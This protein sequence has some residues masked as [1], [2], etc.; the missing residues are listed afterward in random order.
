MYI[1]G[2]DSVLVL[3]QSCFI[4]TNSAVVSAIK[5][6]RNGEN[7]G[8]LLVSFVARLRANIRLQKLSLQIGAL[9]FEQV[10]KVIT[11]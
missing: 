3:F 2:L 11:K 5:H 8:F 10:Q 9:G 1:L 6:T 7:P 4:I